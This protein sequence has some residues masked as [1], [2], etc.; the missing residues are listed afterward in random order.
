MLTAN[1]LPDHDVGTFP[2][3]NNPHAIRPQTVAAAFPLAPV[4]TGHATEL[5]GPRGAIGFL[6]NGVKIDPGTNGA[7]D[8]SGSTCDLGRPAGRWRMEALGQS[9]FRFGE[10]A[11]NAH[12]QPD[13]S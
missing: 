4:A 13:G 6:L 12:V 5:G 10:D 7:C 2:N 8:D 9:N 11:N 3:A 1:G